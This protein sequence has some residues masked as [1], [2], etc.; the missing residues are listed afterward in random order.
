MLH[1][2]QHCFAHAD[3]ERR[4]RLQR[5]A[6]VL[7]LSQHAVED[8]AL[9]L[10]FR[11]RRRITTVFRFRDVR[12]PREGAELDA[13]HACGLQHRGLVRPR[14]R[15]QVEPQLAQVDDG[16]GSGTPA[17]TMSMRGLLMA[18]SRTC[19]HSRSPLFT[20][21]GDAAM[22]VQVRGNHVVAWEVLLVVCQI[23][24]TSTC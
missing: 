9:A 20:F 16:S 7:L 23:C 2:L 14:Q 17:V 13:G 21:N 11:S 4:L 5:A 18:R 24:T 8:S 10:H 12:R 19:S 3:V 15:E 1:Q 22:S 6:S